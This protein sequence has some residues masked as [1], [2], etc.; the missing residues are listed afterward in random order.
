M[1]PSRF[2]LGLGLAASTL[3]IAAPVHAAA[4]KAYIGLFKDNAVAVF[5]TGSNVV[6]KTIP[7]PAGPHGLVVTPDGRWVYASSDGDSVVSVIDTSTDAVASTIQVGQ[8]PH[9]LAITPD[10]TEVLVAGFGTNSVEAIDTASNQL[11]WQVNVPQPHNIA[12]TP[13]GKTAYAGGQQDGAQQVA[14]IDIASG[15]E[16]GSV[17]LDRAP[18]A[19]NVSPDSNYLAYTLAGVDA[20]QVLDLHSLQPDTQVPVG[21]SPHHPLFTPDGKLGMVVAQGPGTLDLFDPSTWTATGSIKVG[22]MPHWIGTTSDAQWAYVTN[23]NSNDV[24]VINLADRSV[25]TTVPVGNAPRK[26]VVQ[27]GASA[28]AAAMPD[29][30]GMAESTPAPAGSS[31]APL[32]AVN[33]GQDSVSIANF[34]FSPKSLTVSAGQSVTFTNND[35]VAHTTTSSAWDSGDIQPGGAYTLTAPSAPGT[36]AF[37][38]SIHPFMT[39]TLIVR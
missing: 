26:I 39:G 33:P 18:R 37:H 1:N 36:Y 30:P 9:G 15:T 13:D 11:V 8:T 5:D 19:L 10:G 38:C 29:M 25:K 28:P 3:L 14:I 21:V 17:P 24:S 35:S 6:M 7:I 20:L 16:T 2:F 22:T 27:P 32:A 31:P 4:P 34:S 23:E 12:I